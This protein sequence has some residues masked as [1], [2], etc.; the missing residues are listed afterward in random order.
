[1]MIERDVPAVLLGGDSTTTHKEPQTLGARGDFTDHLI[2]FLAEARERDLTAISVMP[3]SVA[4]P[5][6]V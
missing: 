3:G 5:G 6:L 1:M 2:R 4:A